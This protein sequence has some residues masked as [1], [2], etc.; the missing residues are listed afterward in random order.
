M[1]VY[2]DCNATSPLEPDVLCLMTHM[3]GH[4]YGNAGSRTHEFGLKALK[5]VEKAREQVAEVVGCENAEV[6]FTSGATESNN[7]AI[8]GLAK[9]LKNAGHTHVITTQIEH[10]AVLE[11]IHQLE[12]QGFRVTRLRPHRGGQI[13][14]KDVSE[15]L[16]EE[17]GL[18][19]IMHANNETG[20]LQPIEEIAN[21]LD[22]HSAMFHVDAAQTFGKEIDP[23]RNRRVDLISISSHKIYGPAG[24]GALV[25]KKR[26]YKKPPLT[27][28]LIGG[29][30]E[31]GLRP[32]TLPVPLIAG[33]GLASELALKNWISRKKHCA[34]IKSEALSAFRE[35]EFSINGDPAITQEHVLNLQF[36]GVDSEAL[37]LTL[38]PL[39]AISNG[40]AC[41]SSSYSPS[42]V[43]TAMGLDEKS[44]SESVRI[45]WSHLTPN[46]N[47]VGIA[48]QIRKTL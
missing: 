15:A 35:L 1:S 5:A 40:S 38:K 11:P 26:Q 18:V 33:F 39:A 32:G 20:V 30:Q 29:G 44:I 34:I 3:Y 14:A 17:T 42:H 48:D 27:P 36:K 43:L 45:S 10:K 31:K 6:I 7:I 23:L 37:M 2:L 12:E 47:W 21:A 13:S 19:S 41:T 16:C 9:N 24:I 25:G 28:I 22:G 46:P 4:E 8:L